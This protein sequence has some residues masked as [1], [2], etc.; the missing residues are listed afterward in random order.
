MLGGNDD[1]GMWT[2]GFDR[3]LGIATHNCCCMDIAQ[4]EVHVIQ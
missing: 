1:K 3:L 2:D 4:G